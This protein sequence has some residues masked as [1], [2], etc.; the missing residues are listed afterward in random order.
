MVLGISS[1]TD[2]HQ[3]SAK[4][5]LDYVLWCARFNVEINIYVHMHIL[6]SIVN[7]YM[8]MYC[9]EWAQ[10]TTSASK[11]KKEDH[12]QGFTALLSFKASASYKAFTAT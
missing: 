7:P 2:A 5:K 8:Y 6:I 11:S 3:R 10:I 9:K 12:H 4:I 1:G